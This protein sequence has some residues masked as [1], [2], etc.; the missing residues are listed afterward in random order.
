MTPDESEIVTEMLIA[1]GLS[2]HERKHELI[3][4]ISKE[5]TTLKDWFRTLSSLLDKKATNSITKST[6]NGTMK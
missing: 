3:I 5:W 1:V 2:V 4:K 6:R